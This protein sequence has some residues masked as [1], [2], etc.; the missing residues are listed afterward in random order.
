MRKAYLLAVLLLSAFAGSARADV[1]YTFSFTAT[2]GP[3]ES[4]VF[5]FSVPTF[6]AVLQETPVA[7][8]VTDGTNH[9]ILDRVVVGAGCFDFLTH[10]PVVVPNG[11]CGQGVDF[12]GEGEIV[13]S[14]IVPATYGAYDLGIT[15]SDFITITPPGVDER[16]VGY[17]RLN[18]VPEPTSAV[19]VLTALLAAVGIKK[20]R[21]PHA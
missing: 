19:L 21:A 15:E 12:P 10:G 2:S 17:A 13:F 11:G 16:A 8:Y 14:G 7:A 5:S 6:L 3:I 20:K 18:V 1:S 9:W 4:F